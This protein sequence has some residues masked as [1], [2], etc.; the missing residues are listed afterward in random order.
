METEINL[1]LVTGT[2]EEKA[3][4]KEILE[5]E[6]EAKEKIR[7][8]KEAEIRLT[9]LKAA[10]ESTQ[11]ELKLEEPKVLLIWA[12][13]GPRKGLLDLRRSISRYDEESRDCGT[14]LALIRN[15]FPGCGSAIQKADD[16]RYQIRRRMEKA[17]AEKKAKEAKG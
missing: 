17:E 11:A 2:P 16:V 7:R 1:E 15:K 10:A 8:F 13:G 14:A 5:K 12:L 3:H 4:W 9:N 6:A